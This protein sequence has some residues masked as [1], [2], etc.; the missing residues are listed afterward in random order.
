MMWEAAQNFIDQ[1]GG[2]VYLNSKVSQVVH[3]GKR[4]TH[5][6][7]EKSEGGEIQE[8]IKVNAEHFISSMPI[9]ELIKR[10]SPAAPQEVLDAANG[11]SYRDFLTVILLVN[12]DNIFHDNWLYIHSPDVKVGRIQNYKN[13]SPDMVPDAAKTSL[14][15]EYFCTVGDEIWNMPDDELLE[16]G[17][18]E[19]EHIGIARREDIFDG[20]VV[21]QPKAYPI[22]NRTYDAYLKTIRAYLEEFENLQTIGRNG[23]H[24]YNNQDHSMLT[25]LL[26]AWNVKGEDHNIWDVNTE[27]SYYEEVRISQEILSSETSGTP[28]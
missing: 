13:W 27:R 15:L 5:V 9:S 4:V 1:G 20:T 22:Y 16:L 11:L 6:S 25:A 18:H 7:V 28:R 17:S 2:K 3:A 23:L 8:E 19:V 14:G 21:R 10:L 26:A 24:K 12:A